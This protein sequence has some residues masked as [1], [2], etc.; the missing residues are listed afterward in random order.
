[1]VVHLI[2]EHGRQYLVNYAL[3][4]RCNIYDMK[5]KRQAALQKDFI[6]VCEEFADG[7]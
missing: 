4:S 7:D 6:E 3:K 1:M 5:G 2:V